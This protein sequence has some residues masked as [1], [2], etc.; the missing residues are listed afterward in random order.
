MTNDNSNLSEDDQLA[1]ECAKHMYKNDA[2]AQA[3]GIKLIQVHCGSSILVM[4]VKDFML[5]G[6]K[7]CHG[8]QIF[9]LA[10]TAFASSVPS[11]AHHGPEGA[12]LQHQ[13]RNRTARRQPFHGTEQVTA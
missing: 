13:G 12:V 2:A 9:S 1:Q 5:N 4:T 6:H 10:D 3:L 11:G 7:T 8:G